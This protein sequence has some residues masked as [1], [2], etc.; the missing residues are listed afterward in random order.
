MKT[1]LLPTQLFD[2]ELI[3][4]REDLPNFSKPG[5]G[6]TLT[7]IGALNKL[8]MQSGL[9]VCPTVATIMWHDLLTSELGARVQHVKTKKETIDRKADF[10]VMSFGIVADQAPSLLDRDNGALILDESHYLKTPDAARTTAVFGEDGDGAGGLYE[11]SQQCWCLT[12]TPIERYADDLW[13]QLR[14]TQ[15]EILQQYG[16][17]TLPEFQRQFCRMEWKEYAQGKIRKYVSIGN[18]STRLLNRML[19]TD[20][21]AI[22]R[23]MSDVDP[24]MPP[25]TERQ[26]F[27]RAKI[28]EELK[29]LLVGKSEA[30]II[31]MV[32]AGGD[33]ITRA[34]RLMGMA[35]LKEVVSYVK[36]QAKDHPVLVGFWHQDVGKEIYKQLSGDNFAANLIWGGTSADARERIRV[37]MKNGELDVLV[38]QIAAMG[39]AMDGLQDSCNHV[40]FAELDWSASKH[41]Q[42]YKRIARKGQLQHVQVDYCTSLEAVDTALTKIRERK[43]AGAA[44]ILDEKL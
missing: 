13:S 6:K 42:F 9:I 33:E 8:R 24:Y 11:T 32:T 39:V 1:P 3:C 35:K 25:T 5:T 10:L 30:D 38:G 12:G 28:T 40:V 41:E 4:A 31:K 23:T 21:G 37:R 20:I 16:A 18:Q 34:R 26:I 29:A 27:T 17:L 2:V 43:A 22:R 19:Y 36:E 15:P 14:A 7:T 44:E